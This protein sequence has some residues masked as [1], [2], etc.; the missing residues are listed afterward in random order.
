VDDAGQVV[1]DAFIPAALAGEDITIPD[2]DASFELVTQDTVDFIFTPEYPPFLTNTRGPFALVGDVLTISD[3]NA[4]FDF[5]GD[6]V[7]DQAVFE[8]VIE[9]TSS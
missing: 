9:R 2:F 3:E 5:D 7:L 1:G 6:Q 4:Y 8:A